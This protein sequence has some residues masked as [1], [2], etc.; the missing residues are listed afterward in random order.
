MAPPDD[1]RVHNLVAHDGPAYDAHGQLVRVR[2]VSF[3]VG[4][5]GPFG[6]T[7]LASELTEE[8]IRKRIHAEAD[9]IRRLV[10]APE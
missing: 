2:I 5:Y 1:L 4:S 8:E 3:M 10:A 7:G 6:L 9:A